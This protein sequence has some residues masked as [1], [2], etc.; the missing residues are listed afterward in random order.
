MK[1]FAIIVA[2]VIAV[3]AVVVAAAPFVIPSD[4]L[5]QRVAERIGTLTGRSATLAGVTTLSIYPHLA[6]SVEGLSIGNPEGMGSDPMIVADRLETRLRLV[7]LLL[8]R[9]EF[10]EFTLT[11]PTIHLVVDAQGHPNWSFAAS[12][13]VAQAT[14]PAPGA[15]DPLAAARDLRLGHLILSNG[16]VLYDNLAS[17]TREQMTE[18]D[19]DVDWPSVSA[20]VSGRGKLVWRGEPV[21]FTGLLAAPI[22]LMRGKTTAARFA[23]A[24]TPLRASFSGRA[25]Q[26]D[27]LRLDGDATLST[28]SMRRTIEWLGTPMG[29]GPILGAAS[30]RGTMAIAGP[31]V[32]FTDA[33][34]ELDG[35]SAEGSLGVSF[36]AAKPHIA[37][38]LTAQRLDLSA[39]LEAVRADLL[40]TGSWL[41]APAR[42]PFAEA[43]DADIT[44]TTG[45]V[46]MDATEIGDT[47]STV[48]IK[49]DDL[50]VVLQGA[51]LYGG[52]IGMHLTTATT[53]NVLSATAHLDIKG[54][55]AS[56]TLA[57]LAG[58]TA[59]GGSMTGTFELSTSGRGWGEMATRVAGKGQ[60]AIDNGTLTG[61]D[62]P[63]VAYLL[64]DPS[65]GPVVASGG[66]TRFATVSADIA[67]DSG[68]I[69]TNDLFMEG[70]EFRLALSGHGSLTSG[71]TEARATLT[72]ATETI[73]L[74]IAGTWQ[75]PAIARAS[76]RPAADE[77]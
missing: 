74:S 11:R 21:E 31:N 65:A 39:Y 67:L 26:G 32:E 35:N 52:E 12:A 64:A 51:N 4:F 10:D 18:L 8:G 22:E 66:T 63:A 24:S 37:G 27:T 62:L 71:A 19:L 5:K 75:Q 61:I 68:T 76:F 50:D 44:F 70:D 25:T 40:A 47:W 34:L 54:V 72:N 3:L 14:A 38:K 58:I 16:T 1:R 28:P 33:D 20:T 42:L 55:P 6:I 77:H 41:I 36:A 69:S 30:V 2:V 23:L 57:N 59:L 45:A 29:T 48:K 49:D 60:I 13:V 15:D 43:V 9:I 53:A 56:P 17:D 46:V 7:P 73:P